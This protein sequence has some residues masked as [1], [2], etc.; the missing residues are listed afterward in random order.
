MPIRTSFCHEQARHL[1]HELDIAAPP[2]DVHAIAS[3]LLLDVIE[4]NPWRWRSRSLLRRDL[5][6]IWVNAEESRRGKRFSVGHEIGHHVLHPDAL[7]FSEH[8]DPES[9]DYAVNPD[10]ALESEADYFSSVLLVAPDW[11]RQD[12]SDGLTVDE[13]V[14]RYDVSREVIFIALEQHRLLSKI[15]TRRR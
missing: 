8:A 7:V 3:G 10:A 14:D 13:L 5:S 12:V 4:K 9:A 6:Q 11:L 1:R 2:V 15:G